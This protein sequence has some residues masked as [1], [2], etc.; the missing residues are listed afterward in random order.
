M[1]VRKFCVPI[2]LPPSSYQLK[3][4]EYHFLQLLFGPRNNPFQFLSVHH[5]VTEFRWLDSEEQD[6]QRGQIDQRQERG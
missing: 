1:G 5:S 3:L 2:F 6:I 4:S